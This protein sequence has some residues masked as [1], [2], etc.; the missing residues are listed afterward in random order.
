MRMSR[1]NLLLSAA[2][3]GCGGRDEPVLTVFSWAGLWGQ[4]FDR[5]LKPLFEKATGA[6]VVFDN[7]W[8]EELPKLLV[9]PPNQPPYDVMIVAPFQIYP[10]IRKGLFARL[11]FNRIPNL[12][13]FAPQALD[14]WIA[15]DRWGLTW[16]DAMHTGVYRTDMGARPGSWRDI[17]EAGPGLYRASYMTLYTFAAA[18]HP[19][20]AAEAIEQDFDGVFEYA[21]RHRHQIRHWWT[22]SPDMTFHLLRGEVPCGN[23]HSVDVFGMF[24]ERKPV[25][26]FLGD[27]RAHFQAIWLVPKGT[28]YLALAHEFLNQFASQAFQRE[29]AA[30]GFPSPIPAVAAERARLDPLWARL[31]PHRPSDFDRLRYYPYDAYVKNWDAMTERW[32]RE[33]L[34]S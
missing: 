26:V 29:Y 2:A 25:D 27:D 5:V 23:I 6:R 28:R 10:V 7:G 32:T 22:T 3:A 31:Y 11:D 18:M 34:A 20:Q 12:R 14:N 8:G 33:I 19:G 13:A 24:A 16:P 1:R 17:L 4:T 9:S 15:R 21:R 30:A